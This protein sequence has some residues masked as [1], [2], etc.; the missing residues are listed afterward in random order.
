M[1][2]S[3][4]CAGFAKCATTTLDAILR[5]HPDIALPCHKETYFLES[6]TLCDKGLQWYENRYYGKNSKRYENKIL[7][8]VNPRD[9]G[10]KNLEKRICEIFGSDIKFIYMI[11]NPVDAAFSFFKNFLFYGIAEPELEKNIWSEGLFDNY[12]RKYLCNRKKES[13]GPQMM[14]AQYLYGR[15]FATALK[16]ISREQMYICVFEDFVRDP[17]TETK[18]ILRF[19]GAD[20]TVDINYNVKENSG[21][22]MPRSVRAIR[23]SQKKYRFW[24]QTYVPCFP[25]LGEFIER[26]MDR[27]FWSIAD[28]ASVPATDIVCMS[29]ET[30]EI[31]RTYYLP[32]IQLLDQVL[33]TNFVEQWNME[34]K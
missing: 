3:F 5:Q 33:G 18:K 7:G 13:H 2:H 19:I 27:W 22:R 8:E 23:I 12:V 29:D 10:C 21:D 14:F 1:K 16:Y 24:E 15:H 6:D 11:R 30:R 25:Y 34:K 4:V 9:S 32:D 26:K 31:L 28:K 20:D 17:E